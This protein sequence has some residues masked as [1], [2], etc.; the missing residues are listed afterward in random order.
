[1]FKVFISA[2][3]LERICLQEM[4][5]EKIQQSSW[6]LLLTKQSTIYLD[7]NVYEEWDYGDPLFTFSESYGI[8]FEPSEID[9]NTVIKSSPD[10]LL[11]EP[12]GAFLLD[13]DN[14]EATTLQNA[15]GVICQSAQE[16]DNCC[17]AANECK[18][19]LHEGDLKHS[20]KELFE[21]G[22]KVPSNS[23]VIIDRYIFSYEGRNRNYVT[24]IENIKQILKSV[25]PITL[26]CDYHLLILFDKANVDSFFNMQQVTRQ[27]SNYV[28]NDLRKTYNVIIELYA[29]TNNC[30]NYECTHNRKIIS[31]YFISSAEYRIK[32]FMNDG[33]ATCNQDIRIESAYSHGLR[34]FSDSSIDT[35]NHLVT[36]LH[37]MHQKGLLE[38]S[39]HSVNATEYQVMCGTDTNSNITDIQN[40]LIL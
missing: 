28:T 40:R 24:G 13:V 38:Y 16:L 30:K 26:Q 14:N 23:L 15:Y 9:F 33:T 20:W 7:K 36:Q 12:Q 37:D 22:V 2:K 35:I 19:S 1:M 32:A 34:D 10:D 8:Q 27:L 11:K 6:F 29:V 18:F 4:P 21:K 39:N 31:N 3:S 25:L 5:K 17:L